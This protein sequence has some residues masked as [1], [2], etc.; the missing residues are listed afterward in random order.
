[1]KTNIIQNIHANPAS[2]KAII[3]LPY[4]GGSYYVFQN[5]KNSFKNPPNIYAVEYPGRN[6]RQNDPFLFTCREVAEE[7]YSEL[8]TI[9]SRYETT[10]FGH[11]LGGVVAYEI[12]KL[13]SHKQPSLLAGLIISGTNPPH[14]RR[15]LT[16]ISDLSDDAFIEKIREYGGI[17][18]V[19]LQDK[20][21]L[22]FITPVL[23][24]DFKLVE[25]YYD[26]SYYQSLQVDIQTLA[27]AEDHSVSPDTVAAWRDCTAGTSCHTTFPGNHFF[28]HEHENKVI[29]LI[30]EFLHRS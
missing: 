20:E 3:C 24:A 11:S 5:W 1:M 9:L 8:D 4:G 15:K 19:I 12:A 26:D 13:I 25:T 28:I 23:R 21:F 2:N 27:G 7:A 30:E 6:S 22:T 29:S 10:L 16:P 18:N 17:S 14:K